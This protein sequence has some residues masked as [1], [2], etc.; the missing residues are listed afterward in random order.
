[1]LHPDYQ[2]DATRIP[3]ARRADPR[4]ATRTWCSAPGSSA[5]RSR[6][7][8]RLEVRLQP[9]PDRRRE[10]RVRAPPV[11]VPH[12]PARLQ[13]APARDDPVPAQLGRLRV[14]PGADRPGRRG[15]RARASARSPSRPATSRR[16]AR[17]AS[18]GAWSTA[19][20]RCGS[21]S[22]TCSTGV[23]IRRSRPAAPAPLDAASRARPEARRAGMRRMRRGA[24]PRDHRDRRSRSSPCS[25]RPVGRRRRGVGDAQ[26]R[27]APVDRGPRRLRDRRRPAARGPLAAC[28]WRPSRGSRPARRSPRC[29][30]ATSPTTSCRRASARSSAAQTSGT[31]TGLSRSTI[32]GHDRHRARRRHGRRGRDRL[33]RDPRA[34]GA[35][36]R[37]VR[38][39]RGARRDGAA[40]RR[41]RRW[42]SPPTGCRAPSASREF[43]ERWPRV[44]P[45]SSGCATGWRSR[46]T[47]ARWALAVVLSIASWSCTVLAFAAAAQAVGVEPTIGPGGAARRRDEPRDGDPGG[48][49]VRRHVR[50]RG[51][52]DRRVG[53]ASTEGGRAR[54]RDPRPRRDAAR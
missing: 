42:G 41:R 53:R 34:L 14:R 20:R 49:R 36:D 27:R 26:D 50:A 8:C 52:H 32:L 25:R 35:R 13:P 19:C 39:A 6:A 37:R 7:A 2:Y 38:G 30:S 23:G 43:L 4:R 21:S 46:A 29:W 18:S 54:V 51:G 17:W 11:R 40:R 12:G 44:R 47:R 45:C 33:D 22:A 48:A 3:A 31:R 28:C 24:R 9:V 15:R 1:M 10:R 5:T 16:R